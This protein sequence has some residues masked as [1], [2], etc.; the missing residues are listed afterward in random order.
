MEWVKRLYG[1][2]VGLDTA[3][4]IYFVEEHPIYLT[5]VDPFFEAMGRGD[6]E[7]VTSTLTLLEVLVRPYMR[8]DRYLVA[9]YSEMILETR[10]LTAISLSPEIAA[11]AARIRATH[12]TATPDSIQLATALVSGATTFLSNDDDLPEIPGLTPVV[13]KRLLASK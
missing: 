12:Q 10:H 3:P 9:Q 7:V 5:Q 6:I 4:L 2:T 13:L 1:T 11:E 8:G